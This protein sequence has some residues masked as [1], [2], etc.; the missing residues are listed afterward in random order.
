MDANQFAAFIQ[1]FNTAVANAI[2]AGQ[3]QVQ[4][5]QQGQGQGQAAAPTPKIGVKIP[6]Y[7]GDPNENVVI[8]LLQVQNLF[9]AQGIVDGATKIHYV[10]TGF[11][12]TAL[13]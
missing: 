4:Q 5:G 10:A 13:H 9:H 8:W 3:A 1:N 11:E 2:A 6:T 7:K 12:G